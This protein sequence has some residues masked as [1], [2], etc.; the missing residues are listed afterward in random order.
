VYARTLGE[1]QETM[2]TLATGVSLNHVVSVIIAIFGGILW[3]T[4]GLQYLFGTAAI[5]AMC[6]MIF[7]FSLPGPRVMRRP[8]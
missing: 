7:C 2:T 5:F 3:E 1:H 4:L 8:A 6:S